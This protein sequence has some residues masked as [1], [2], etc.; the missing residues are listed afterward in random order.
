MQLI[1]YTPIGT[2]A[3]TLDAT[4]DQVT[5]LDHLHHTA[6]QGTAAELAEAIGFFSRGK[7]YEWALAAAGFPVDLGDVEVSYEPRL[8]AAPRH[9]TFTHGPAKAEL[10]LLEIVSTDASPERVTIPSDYS[11]CVPPRL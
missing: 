1:A 4:G 6:W 7:P 8:P 9:V 3:M 11:C 2:T 5:F 10:T